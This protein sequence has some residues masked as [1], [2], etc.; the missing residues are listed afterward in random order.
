MMMV[1]LSSWQIYLVFDFVF[2]SFHFLWPVHVH[3]HVRVACSPHNVV[4]NHG[5]GFLPHSIAE[6]RCIVRERCHRAVVPVVQRQVL[7]L[8]FVCFLV[9]LCVYVCVCACVCA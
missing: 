3:V 2:I 7:D 5:Y 9:C 1:L 6:K 8:S 4:F